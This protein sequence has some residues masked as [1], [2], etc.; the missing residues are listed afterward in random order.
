[1][2]A[3]LPDS[4]D[5]LT[6]RGG[7]RITYVEA[8]CASH[9]YVITPLGPTFAP[10]DARTAV[11]TVRRGGDRE[12]AGRRLYLGDTLIVQP[13]GTLLVIAPGERSSGFLPDGQPRCSAT[14]E[15]TQGIAQCAF[16]MGHAPIP[17]PPGSGAPAAWDHG[18]PED[19]PTWW[20][21]D[22]FGA[23]R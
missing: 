20:I 9:G 2:S 17:R 3:D 15:V 19:G 13:D 8:W 5:R 11:A 7:G 21:D 14:L 1:M 6:L 23:S 4:R 10:P 12:A 16:P 22:A 18:N